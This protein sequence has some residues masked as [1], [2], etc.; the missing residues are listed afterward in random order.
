VSDAASAILGA[1][2]PDLLHYFERR[3]R[4]DAADLL[5]ETLVVAWRRVDDLPEDVVQA[6]MWLFG[7]ARMVLLGHARDQARRSRLADRLRDLPE[8]AAN[9]ADQALDVRAAIAKLPEADAELVRLVHWDGLTLA[10][11]ATVVGINASTARGRYQRARTALAVS[12]AHSVGPR[13][14]HE[15]PKPG[16]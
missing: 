13:T 15:L 8:P 5:A 9:D 11:A 3:D 16:R 4:N 2:A 7:I 6:R 12:L 10:E 14:V 1:T